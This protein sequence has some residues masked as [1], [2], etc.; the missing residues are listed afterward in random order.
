MGDA[1]GDGERGD[2]LPRP[3]PDRGRAA[4]L[5]YG[6]SFARKDDARARARWIE[7]ELAAMRVPDLALIAPDA[8]KPPTV[9][10]MAER[11]KATRVGVSAGTASTYTVNLSR[12]I[13][14]LGARTA[15]GIR[16]ADVQELVAHLRARGLARESI[17]KTLSTFAQ[18]LDF[19]ELTRRP[20]RHR[21]V[22]LPPN[23]RRGGELADRRSRHRRVPGARARLPSPDDRARRDRDARHRARAIDVG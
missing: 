4:R 22:Q 2:A 1:E 15:S 14:T 12:I 10:E 7:S 3:I 19:A 6:G 16:P 21:T 18:V 8:V 11:W 5:L 9:A 23:D 13:P 17:R 20:V